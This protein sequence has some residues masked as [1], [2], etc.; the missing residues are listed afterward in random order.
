[1][2]SRHRERSERTTSGRARW[3][4]RPC[5]AHCRYVRTL[6]R[7]LRELRPDLIHTNSLKAAL[8]G[9]VAGRLAGIP[10]IWHIRDRIAP[11]YL[12]TACR[13][14]VRVGARVPSECVIAN[15]ARHPRDAAA[16]LAVASWSPTRSSTTRSAS[17][18]H[19]H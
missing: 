4:S 17:P 11:D 2:P 12:P 13:R 9:G 7:R 18:R 19:G 5:V 10:V 6:R 1:M 15:S 14:M 8:Y 3:A 16:S